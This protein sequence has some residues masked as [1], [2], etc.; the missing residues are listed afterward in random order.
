MLC[1]EQKNIGKGICPR[2]IIMVFLEEHIRSCRNC[3]RN[4][5]GWERDICF[6]LRPWVLFEF[7]SATVPSHRQMLQE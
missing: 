4:I 6:P 1:F 5:Q 7:L 3:E 2:M